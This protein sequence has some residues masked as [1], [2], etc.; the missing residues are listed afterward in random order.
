MSIRSYRDSDLLAVL[1]IYKNSKLDELQFEGERFELVPLNED[2]VR[3][4][5]FRESD[6]YVFEKGGIVAYC[7]LHNSNI[8][9][10][11]VNPKFRRMGIARTLLEFLLGK[12]K[13][14]VSL[15]VAKNN[16][17]AKE[18]YI[19]YGFEVENEFSTSYNSVKAVAQKM[20]LKR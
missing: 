7:A 12:V 3:F 18:L 5:K 11:Y 9:A 4:S 6:I 17:P 20:V 2:P 10:I 19:E 14:N 8:E 15:N 16:Q 13:G 1:D